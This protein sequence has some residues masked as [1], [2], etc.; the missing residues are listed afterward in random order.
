M[1]LGALTKCQHEESDAVRVSGGA[2]Y[3]T[4]LQHALHKLLTEVH[5]LSVYVFVYV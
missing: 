2:P 3:A 1:C 4:L 5:V